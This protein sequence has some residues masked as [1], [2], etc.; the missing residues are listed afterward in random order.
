MTPRLARVL[1]RHE[2]GSLDLED[3]S[4]APGRGWK[5]V[6][7]P[8][9]GVFKVYVA[10]GSVVLVEFILGEGPE[11]IVCRMV[12]GQIERIEAPDCEVKGATLEHMRRLALQ[13]AADFGDSSAVA[14]L[15][16]LSDTKSGAA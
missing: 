15:T 6:L 12:Q 9:V 10:I 13:A 3:I 11:P 14:A 4:P 2:D 8:L 7:V 16:T 1:V 5:R